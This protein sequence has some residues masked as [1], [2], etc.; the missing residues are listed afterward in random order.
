MHCTCAHQLLREAAAQPEK[1]ACCDLGRCCVQC[2]IKNHI[3]NA[4]HSS[5][6]AFE[7]EHIVST[8]L[9]QVAPHLKLGEQH[10]A[11]E[12]L[13]LLIN[14]MG[15]GYLSTL[16]RGWVQSSVQCE[17]CGHVSSKEEF[18]GGDLGLEVTDGSISTV[19]ESLSHHT[20]VETL[21]GANA[22]Q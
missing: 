10:D 1:H 12:F 19:K 17:E 3:N 6:I 14:G 7:P 15:E 2:S 9:P 4:F 11:H 8:V 5:E 18:I 21:S 16:F 13:R 20:K 22:Y